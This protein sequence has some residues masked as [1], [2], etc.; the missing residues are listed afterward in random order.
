MMTPSSR[1]MNSGLKCLF[2]GAVDLFLHRLEVEDSFLCAKP[3]F[4]GSADQISA[5]IRGHDDDRIA[6]IDLAS[7]GIGQSSFFQ[8]LQQEVH[9]IRMCFFHFIKEY[10]AI[11]ALPHLFRE[12]SPFFMSD[13]A[14]R[15]SCHPADRKFLHVFRHVDLDE[16][17]FAAEHMDRELSGQVCFSDASWAK[18]RNAPMGRLGSLISARL[19][20]IARHTVLT[21]IVLADDLAF[22]RFFHFEDFVRLS[23]GQTGERDAC[24]FGDDVSDLFFID[25]RLG[26]RLCCFP[27]R[28]RIF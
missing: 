9:D 14:R 3:H 19:R 28:R 20:R 13:I 21:R 4:S 8:N 26:A 5:E 7:E 27:I 22:E 24:L 11:G 16:S 2:D 6:E 10:D 15:R 18:K 17:I 25:D 12:L 1:L 23:F